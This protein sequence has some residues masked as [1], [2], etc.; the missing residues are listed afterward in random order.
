MANTFAEEI[1]IIVGKDEAKGG[2]DDAP[3][4]NEILGR[5]GIGYVPAGNGAAAGKAGAPD[6]T[7]AP[8]TAEGTVSDGLDH[9]N[10]DV[11]AGSST[12][13]SF[14]T[15][16]PR[17]GIYETGSGTY[18]PDEIMNDDAGPQLSTSLDSF[19]TLGVVDLQGGMLKQL[20]TTDCDTGQTAIIRTDGIFP[21]PE[22]EVDVNG[23]VETAEWE[24]A[25]TP[26]ELEGFELGFFWQ[27]AGSGAPNTAEG[28]TAFASANVALDYMNGLASP[29]A[30]ATPG[31]FALVEMDQ[32][33]ETLFNPIYSRDFISGGSGT[34]SLVTLRSSCTGSPPVDDAT[35]PSE[36]PLETSWPNADSEY[37]MALKEGIFTTNE[38]DGGVP[39]NRTMPKSTVS[40][41]FGTDQ[42]GEI[43]A[44]KN[45]SFLLA[46]T[47][48][49]NGSITSGSVVRVFNSQGRLIAYTDSAGSGAYLAR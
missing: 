34:F 16:D 4:K 20:N 23:F 46:E 15:N 5:R 36:A 25:D 11:T 17:N 6:E 28:F 29:P 31:S 9:N 42:F 27:T 43:I 38:F 32:Q 10:D 7:I 49:Q 47:D 14:D 12:G 22:E 13:A 2:I 18:T 21:A 37:K 48:T 3:V 30:G 40:F 35:C 45:G 41:C 8:E 39:T 44:G 26:P 24:D 19:S 1:N 33:S